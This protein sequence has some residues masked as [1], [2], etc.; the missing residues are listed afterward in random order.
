MF[1]P[2]ATEE[3]IPNEVRFIY[4]TVVHIIDKIDLSYIQRRYLL[5]VV[6][7][8]L[9]RAI[10]LNVIF[11][12]HRVSYHSILSHFICVSSSRE[13]ELTRNPKNVLNNIS[14]VARTPGQ[15]IVCGAY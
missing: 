2:E 7:V 10:A 15:I 14:G 1:E 12:H 9:L 4:A 11:A 5:T 13:N 8:G 6:Y 3:E